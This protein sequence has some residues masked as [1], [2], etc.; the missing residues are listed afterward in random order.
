MSASTDEWLR[1][2]KQLIGLRRRLHHQHRL[3][4]EELETPEERAEMRAT[5]DWADQML[6]EISERLGEWDPS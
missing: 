4:I 5:L 3:I 1:L 6:D 2:M